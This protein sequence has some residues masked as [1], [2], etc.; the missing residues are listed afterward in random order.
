MSEAKA[1]GT[2]NGVPVTDAVVDEWNEEVERRF[3]A[4]A[5]GPRR[6]GRPSLGTD[7]VSAVLR[8]R[9]DR[10]LG[11]ALERRVGESGKSRSQVARDAL[12]EH[13]MPA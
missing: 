4:D 3:P 5:A 2:V 10:E 8:V 7:G 1:Y 6:R 12:R 11:E 9:I 13:L